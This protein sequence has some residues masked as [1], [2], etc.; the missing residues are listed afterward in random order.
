[1][2]ENKNRLH[3]RAEWQEE[4]MYIEEQQLEEIAG[5]YRVLKAPDVSK[6]HSGTDP[7]VSE[8][9]SEMLSDIESRGLD[10]VRQYA[11]DLDGWT[12][13]DLEIPINTLKQ[14]AGQLSEELCRALELGV[15][16]TRAFAEASRSHLLDFEVEITP[17]LVCGQRYIPV[18]RVGA[19][20]PAG[21]LPILTSAAMTIGVAKAAGV[22]SVIACTPPQFGADPNPAILYTTYL[23]NA[24]RVFALGGVQALAAMAFGLLGDMPVDML[25]GAGNAWVTEAKRQLFGRVGIDLLAG[26]SEVAV[27]ADE[28]ADPEIVAADL[29][30]QAEHGPSSPAALITTSQ[31]LAEAVMEI[32]PRQLEGLA[33]RDI[34]GP[35][36]RDYG[37]VVVADN[38]YVAARLADHIAPEHLEVQAQDLEFFRTNL[39]H[40]GSLFL[41][42]WSTVAYS[43]KGISGTNHVLPTGKTARFGAGLSV[44]RFLRPL[45]YQRTERSATRALGEPVAVISEHEGFVAHQAT[46]TL[47]LALVKESRG[48]N[49]RGD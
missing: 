2:S 9:V 27:I 15:E 35:A 33:T 36:W 18:Q 47:R 19:Y 40:Y 16:H 45:T 30:G 38:D 21:R 48:N 26:P 4:H 10:A 23:A 32:I 25:V 44:G 6:P 39:L 11:R 7:A 20:L 34:A 8:K 49:D 28:S 24:D 43:D 37:L 12:G 46:A 22:P 13:T 1:M 31:A 29:L 5:Q 41:G 42:S 3:R 14:S 17:G